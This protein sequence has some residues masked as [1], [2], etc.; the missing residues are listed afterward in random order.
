MIERRSDCRAGDAL[1][2]LLARG[3]NLGDQDVIGIGEGVGKVVP[4]HLRAAV[5]VRLPDRPDRAVRVATACRFQ[6]RPNLERVMGVVVDHRH[7]ADLAF[8]LEASSR[9]P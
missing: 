7:A 1:N 2:R 4:E 6:R 8:Q 3:V 5:S 9:R